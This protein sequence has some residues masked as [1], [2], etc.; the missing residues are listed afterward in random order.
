[1][2]D[3]TEVGFKYFDF[4][5]IA[6]FGV[7]CRGSGTGILEIRADEQ[8]VG[9]IR[10]SPSENWQELTGRIAFPEGVHGLSLRYHGAGKVYILEL[11]FET[12]R[13]FA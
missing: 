4:H 12:E 3:G 9:Q 6:A 13:V 8:P 5:Q 11:K 7:T 2:A 1:M 10:I